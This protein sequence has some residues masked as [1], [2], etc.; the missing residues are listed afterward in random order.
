MYQIDFDR[1]LASKGQNDAGLLNKFLKTHKIMP[2]IILSS[3]A[4]RTKETLEISLKD[5]DTSE[6]V[7]FKD[8]LY[9]ASTE[10]V[11]NLIQLINEEISSLMIIG[12]NP[13]MHN[14][15]ERLSKQ[16]VSKFPTCGLASIVF[17]DS[18]KNIAKLVADE[19]NFIT[20]KSLKGP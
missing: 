1:P 12:H 18:W 20:P 8:E 4:A 6:K 15:F 10:T 5:I 14:V 9:H 11:L 13:S 19:I 16:S 3:P 2:D 17:Q 7:F